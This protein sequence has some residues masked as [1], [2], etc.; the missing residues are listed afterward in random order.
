MIEIIPSTNVGIF[1]PVASGKTYLINQ[2]LKNE[3]RYLRFD[4]TGETTND[5][6]VEHFYQPKPLLERLLENPYYFRIAYHPGVNVM[7]HYRWCSR[8]LWQ[9][10]TAR[11]LVM[12]EYHRVCPQRMNLD[13]DVETSLRLARHNLL[14]IIGATQRPQDVSKLF[15][16][17]C[18]MCVIYHSQEENFLNA[19]A[20][21]WGSD[22]AEAIEQL[23][24]NVYDDVSKIS[25]QVPQCVIVTR[26]GREARIYDFKTDKFVNVTQFL[27]GESH[28]NRD[29]EQEGSTERQ[30]SVQQASGDNGDESEV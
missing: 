26:D 8:A 30:L 16:D 22:V 29:L 7:E 13:P 20:G 25:I 17:S 23:R 15:V 1:A 2:W 5:T 9:L 12:D 6:G 21:H 14:G 18:R 28:D 27:N 11:W 4:Y 3:N 24:P 10:N 19:C